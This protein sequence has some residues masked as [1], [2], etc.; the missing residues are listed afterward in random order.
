MPGIPPVAQQVKNLA[1]AAQVTEEAWVQSLAQHSG[2]K[3]LV[4]L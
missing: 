2:L 1:A 4:W 3:D